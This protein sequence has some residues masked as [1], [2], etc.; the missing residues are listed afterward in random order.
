MPKRILALGMAGAWMALTVAAQTASTSASSGQIAAD[1]V[2]RLGKQLAL[3]AEQ[4]AQATT[5]FTT[6]Q[7]ALAALRSNLQTAQKTLQTAIT[8]NDSATIGAQSTEIGS[9]TGQRV[10]AQSTASA[11]FYAILTPEQQ[12]KYKAMPRLGEARLAGGSH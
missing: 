3:S 7:N 10:L 1:M 9:L 5:I 6:E 2:A 8:S 4:Q 12:G 11:A